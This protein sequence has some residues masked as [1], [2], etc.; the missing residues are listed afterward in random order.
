V[1][2]VFDRVEFADVSCCHAKCGLDYGCR[3]VADLA[4]G[5]AADAQGD[6]AVVGESLNNPASACNV[7]GG[8]NLGVSRMLAFLVVLAVLLCAVSPHVASH[9]GVVRAQVYDFC[10]GDSNLFVHKKLDILNAEG[11]DTPLE[12][13]LGVMQCVVPIGLGP[14]TQSETVI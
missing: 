10:G 13:E 1:L 2:A 9:E 4:V 7:T 11:L 5:V 3:D 14:L 12:V 8:S 6:I